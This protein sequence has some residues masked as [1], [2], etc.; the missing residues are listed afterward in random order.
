MCEDVSLTLPVTPPFE[1]GLT[2]AFLNGFP[3]TH[4]EQGTGGELRKATR[5]GGQTV[6]FV[7]REGAGGLVVTLHPERP[8]DAAQVRA[9]RERIAF[10]L[11]V[12]VDLQPFYGLAGRDETFR[13]VLKT[14]HGFHQ[15]RFLTPF[16]AACWA[17]LTQR[18][19]LAQARR[20]KRTLSD[21]H[22]GGWEGRPA[23]PEPTDLAALDGGDFRA[24]I[25]N[26][27]RARALHAVT[28][29]FQG[30]QTADLVAAPY[31]AVRDWLLSIHGIGEW[32]ALFILLRGLGRTE[33]LRV[34]APDSALL[35]ELLR[36]ARPVYGDLTPEQLW[37]IADGYGEQQGQWAIHLRSRSALIPDRERDV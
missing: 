32:S 34:N 11:A 10:F 36:A 2:L 30:M 23:F 19:P 31:D 9:L 33:R 4:G 22:G 6:G 35:K 15:P 1:F 14:L 17:V 37:Q 20:M 7:V 21:A 8:L 18:Q 12:D 27:R 3:P 5:Q 24:L 25:P 13:P 26:D 16:E 29:A 28:R